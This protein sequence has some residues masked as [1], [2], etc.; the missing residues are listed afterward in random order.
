MK[1]QITKNFTLKELTYSDTAYKKNISNIPS[2]EEYNNMK[3]LCEEVLQPIRDHFGK[4]VRINSCFRCEELNKAVGGA[5]NSQHRTGQAADIE[6]IGMS[7]YEL[8]QWIRDNLEYDQLILEYANNISQDKNSGW[9][10]VSFV[11][12]KSNRKQ[13]LTINNNGTK[14]GLY[15]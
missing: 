11:S 14:L 5:K 6:I 13:V 4:P 9:V 1:N 8:A 15:K 3:T 12:K 2:E 7:N 10:H